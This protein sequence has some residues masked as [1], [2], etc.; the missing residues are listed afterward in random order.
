LFSPLFVS[1]LSLCF[2]FSLLKNSL[3]FPPPLFFG[4]PPLVFIGRGG[5]GHLTLVMA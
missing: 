5:Q 1:L 3:Y 2:G 4:T